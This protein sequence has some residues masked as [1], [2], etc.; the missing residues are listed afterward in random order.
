M[1]ATTESRFELQ[2][3]N[4]EIKTRLRLRTKYVEPNEQEK[5]RRRGGVIKKRTIQHT[6]LFVSWISEA[7]TAGGIKQAHRYQMLRHH[8]AC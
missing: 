2:P 4:Q 5:G 3:P 6:P 1:Y 8:G 7:N